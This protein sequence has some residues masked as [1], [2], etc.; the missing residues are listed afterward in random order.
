MTTTELHVVR[1]PCWVRPAPLPN[2]TA[3]RPYRP[4]SLIPSLSAGQLGSWVPSNVGACNV[5]RL[6]K[7]SWT[8]DIL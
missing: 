1:R 6:L 8:Y 2:A 7:H 4:R 5:E 3:L